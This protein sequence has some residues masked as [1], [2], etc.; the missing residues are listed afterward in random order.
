[1]VKKE[2]LQTRRKALKSMLISLMESSE[3]QKGNKELSLQLI[4]K[5]LR[6]Q[7]PEVVEAA[8]EDG[9]TVS[10]PYFTERQ[11]QI[12]LELLG[13]SLGQPVLLSYKQVVD[14]SLLDEISRPGMNKPG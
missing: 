11:F 1:M 10:Y 6:L 3:R 14:H 12:A 9:L 4:R 8:H 2:V 7:N 5:H 13:K